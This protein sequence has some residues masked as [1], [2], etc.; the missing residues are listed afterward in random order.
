MKIFLEHCP[1]YF[2]TAA[3]SSTGKYHPKT[4]SKRHGLLLHTKR[5]FTVYEDLSDSWL[6]Q[7]VVQQWEVNCGRAA[8]LLHDLLKYGEP[9]DSGSWQRP[10]HTVS[11]HDR[12][13]SNLLREQSDV[14]D[15]VVA[16]VDSHNGPWGRG[17]S[18]ENAL[19]M[20]HHVA[21]M[22][23]SRRRIDGIAVYKPCSELLE[24]LDDLE[25]CDL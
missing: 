8:I 19:E 22:V 21:D 10:E 5:A 20:L 13:A 2:W 18:P 16:C 23:A 1:D 24:V 6:N 11:N 15:E 17:K 7:G 25:T 14:P 4:H 12:L 3:A 9:D